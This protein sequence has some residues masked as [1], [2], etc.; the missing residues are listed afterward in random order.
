MLAGHSNSSFWSSCFKVLGPMLD[1]FLKKNPE[2]LYRALLW[3]SPAF[4][5]TSGV[6]R[7]DQ[8]LL[9]KAVGECPADLMTTTTNG[10]Q[11]IMSIE[12][13]CAK[14]PQIN[15]V[16]GS[17]VL[18]TVIASLGRAGIS[19]TDIQLEYPWRPALIEFITIAKKGCS[20]WVKIAKVKYSSRSKIAER[21]NKWDAELGGIRG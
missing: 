20:K 16:E 18:N 4:K 1:G 12:E 15:R 19:H 2:N 17:R 10:K 6:L 7:R 11:R 13:L 5:S 8:N 14:H 21:E 9:I 3:G